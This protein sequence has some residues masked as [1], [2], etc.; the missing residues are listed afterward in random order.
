MGSFLSLSLC[1]EQGQFWCSLEKTIKGCTPD[2]CSLAQQC[3]QPQA[4]ALTEEKLTSICGRGCHWY[5]LTDGRQHKQPGM[6]CEFG[7]CVCAQV[8]QVMSDSEIPWTTAHKATLSMGFSRQ[9]SWS[10]LPFPSPGD[11][12]NPG[13]EPVSPALADG[14]FTTESP[15][16]PKY[17]T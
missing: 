6:L 3:L 5:Q 8:A 12:P 2:G 10:G 4:K 16:K 14:F 11:L 17:S 7:K 1:Q 13:I 9:E 15:G